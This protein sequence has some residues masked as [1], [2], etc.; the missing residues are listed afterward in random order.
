MMKAKLGNE[1][2]QQT[3]N[4]K[5][6]ITRKNNTNS[7]DGGCSGHSTDGGGGCGGKHLVKCKKKTSF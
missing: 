4:L 5:I 6:P 7:A 2:Q 3:T 1:T